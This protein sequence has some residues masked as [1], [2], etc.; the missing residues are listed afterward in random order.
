V[1]RRAEITCDRAGL[2]CCRDLNVS[3]RS[4]AKLALGSQKLY[5]QLDIEEFVKQ[6]EESQDGPGRY[7]EITSSH[8]WLPKRILAIRAFA[9]SAIYRKHLGLEGGISMHEVDEK[10]HEIIKVVG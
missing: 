2:L 3:T 6:F 5:E 9:D 8:P 10:V 7:K 4:F 1:A